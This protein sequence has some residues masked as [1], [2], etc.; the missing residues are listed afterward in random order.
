M[1]GP[2]NS[3]D[4]LVV[5]GGHNGLVAAAYMARAG[6]AV[7]VL[8]ARARLGGPCGSMEFLPG[9]RVGFS[10]SPGSLEPR[11]VRE[12]ELPRFGLE[13]IRADPTVVHCFPD[14]CFIGWREPALVDAQL[15][16]VAPGEAARYHGLLR[17]L[18]E[19]AQALGVSMF[20]S[21]PPLTEIER[22]LETQEQRRMF[23]LAL[24]GSLADLLEATGLAGKTKAVLGMIGVAT[25]LAPPSAPGTAVGLMLRPLSLA[26]SPASDAHDPHRVPLR[27]STGLP[28]G[29]MGT[30]VDALEA[31]CRRHGATIHT[32]ARVARIKGVGGAVAGAVTAEGEE[33]RAPI[34]VSSVNPR[35]LFGELLDPGAVDP[36]LRRQIVEAPMAGSAFKM[37][38]ALDG[39][40][41]YAG[42]PPGVET[43]RVAGSQFRIGPSLPYIE[44]AALDGL[45]GRPSRGPIMWGLIPTVTSPA[46][47]PPGRHLLSVNVWHAPYRL[48]EGDWKG[49]RDRFGRHCIDVLSTLMPGLADRIV[50]HRF[51][52]PVDIAEE[53]NL[54][55]AN[56]THGDMLAE[57]L[58]GG[59]PHA[60]FHDYRGPL[61]GLYLTGAGTWPGGYVTGI[62]GRNASQTVLADLRRGANRRGES[63]AS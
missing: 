36:E 13:F 5:G 55:E 28:V 52:S 37:V 10:N 18:E 26:S 31:C 9:Y 23:R 38:L 62:P 17:S 34:V 58:F 43:E 61:R 57:R 7:A 32:G 25:N 1:T 40:P 3:F 45:A 39:V 44:Q 27:G 20:E 8:E 21:P 41:R 42:L 22:R 50:A 6:L 33:F 51:M 2:A 46:M 16:A 35:I 19:F 54:V 59:R 12:L 14:G 47:A 48:A 11:V 24:E 4:A 29:G 60:A 53:L 56:I 49:E 15:E 30:I 63:A